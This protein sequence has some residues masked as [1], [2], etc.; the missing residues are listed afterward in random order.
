VQ[1]AIHDLSAFASKDL[2]PERLLGR[3]ANQMIEGDV[4]HAQAFAAYWEPMNVK[5]A[6]WTVSCKRGKPEITAW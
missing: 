1:E 2:D 3:G 4:F 6:A 5:P